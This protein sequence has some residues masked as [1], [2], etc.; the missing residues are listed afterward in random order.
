MTVYYRGEPIPSDNDGPDW[1]SGEVGEGITDQALA[2]TADSYSRI[3]DTRGERYV[4]TTTY[5][6]PQDKIVPLYEDTGVPHNRVYVVKGRER[7][8]VITV[9]TENMGRAGRPVVG[10]RQYTVSSRGQ[11]PPVVTVGDFMSRADFKGLACAVPEEGYIK[12]VSVDKEISVP[13]PGTPQHSDIGWMVQSGLFSPEQVAEMDVVGYAL[14]A[15]GKK[16]ADHG[17]TGFPR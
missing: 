3:Q 14:D 8:E 5:R 7:L 16:L 2:R 4:F 11:R 13:V 10:A 1:S 12:A 15:I 17:F 6:S 9:G